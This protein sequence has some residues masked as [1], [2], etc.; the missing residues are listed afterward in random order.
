MASPKLSRSKVLNPLQMRMPLQS[1]AP[2]CT[3]A[4][5]AWTQLISPLLQQQP[6]FPGSVCHHQAPHQLG[7]S[8]DSAWPRGL[9]LPEART[10]VHPPMTSVQPGI[11]SASFSSS[12]HIAQ[13]CAML[14]DPQSPSRWTL[15]HL[16]P[17][18]GG[19]GHKV[20]RC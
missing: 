7:I 8:Q 13:H 15:Q 18:V 12:S 1:F 3:E 19:A 2:C 11:A 10:S 4:G 14:P 6:D 16:L 17:L 9:G 5:A 20:L